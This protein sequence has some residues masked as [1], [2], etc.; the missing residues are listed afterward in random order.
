MKRQPNLSCWEALE[1]YPPYFVRL[2]AKQ[3]RMS[4]PSDTEIAIRSGI[5]LDRIR[6]MVRMADYNSITIAEMRAFFSACNFDPTRG[7]DRQ[8]IWQYNHQ[9]R[10]RGTRP[11]QY[12]TQHPKY[13]SE[14]LP[15]IKLA[16]ALLGGKRRPSAP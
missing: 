6:E 1:L 8:R 15:L 2:L 7:S 5:P 14:I 9:C 12:L 10:K 16:G 3:G 11:L 4:A 13:E